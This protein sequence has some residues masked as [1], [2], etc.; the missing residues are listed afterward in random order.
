MKKLLKIYE[1]VRLIQFLIGLNESYGPIRNQIL[2]MDPI[3]DTSK[4]YALL[5]QKERQCE[6]HVLRTSQQD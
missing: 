1:H 5:I 2:L 4:A 6:L 3:P